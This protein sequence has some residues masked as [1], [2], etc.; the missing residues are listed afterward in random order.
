MDEKIA[1]D[2]GLFRNEKKKELTTLN[3]YA[4]LMDLV[5]EMQALNETNEKYEI[6]LF[7]SFF[8]CLNVVCR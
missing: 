4:H 1:L 2:A 5:G 6:F 7:K 3:I 8:F